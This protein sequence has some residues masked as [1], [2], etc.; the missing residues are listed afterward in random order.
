MGRKEELA[1]Q[2]FGIQAYLEVRSLE[3]SYVGTDKATSP[4]FT[5]P[6]EVV[7]SFIPPHLYQQLPYG[8][9]PADWLSELQGVNIVD[10]V[11]SRTPP[12][13]HAFAKVMAGTTNNQ[14]RQWCTENGSWC[15]PFNVVVLQVTMGGTNA[16]LCHGAGL[17]TSTLSDMVVEV[18][19]VDAQGRDQ[20]V[21]DPEELK[22]ASGSFGLLGIVTSIT[23]QLEAMTVAQMMPVQRPVVLGLPPPRG[24]PIPEIIQKQ[25]RE[26]QITEED[27]ELAR[28]EF[29]RRCEEDHFHE[30]FWFPYQKVAWVNTWKR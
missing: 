4:L 7:V 8:D 25:T 19:Y 28:A 17:S 18:C 26:A 30:W 10:S 11:D 22:A 6:G 27:V 29:V 20:R 15:L 21:S 16:T 2:S 12:P 5:S 1:G 24:Y 3:G 13:G 14:F 23:L 9:P